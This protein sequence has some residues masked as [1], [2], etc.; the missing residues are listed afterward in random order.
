MFCEQVWM[1]RSGGGKREKKLIWEQML[2][3]LIRGVQV[4]QSEGGW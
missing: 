2:E 1:L 3:P 4:G